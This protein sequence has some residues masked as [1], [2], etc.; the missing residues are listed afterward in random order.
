MKTLILG[1]GNPILSDD[2]VGLIIA[3][4]LERKIAGADVVTTSLAGM[5]LL[6]IMA[7]YDRMFLIDALTTKGSD[8]GGLRK[9]T[10]GDGCLHL[11]SSHGI[12]FF[13][14]VQLGKEM[15]LKMPHISGIYGIE[16][17]DEVSFGEDLTPPLKEK[18]QSI[19]QEILTEI[20][21]LLAA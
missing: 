11:F 20:T 18:I 14:L 1:L 10:E 9:L 21:T 4:A 17:G 15:G 3:R 5:H 12:N 8:L 19:I 16:I 7:G 2:G 6:D 13:D